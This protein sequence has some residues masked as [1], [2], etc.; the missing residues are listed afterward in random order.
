V[1]T[2]FDYTTWIQ[3]SMLFASIALLKGSISLYAHNTKQPLK[4]QYNDATRYG[5]QVRPL[6]WSGSGSDEGQGVGKC[7]GRVHG[8][9]GAPSL[10]LAFSSEC[11]QA[12]HQGRLLG[13]SASQDKRALGGILEG[14]R[15]RSP[16]GYARTQP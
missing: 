11:A 3:V 8:A 1:D 7:S 15:E 10:L 5:G 13:C 4:V 6:T 2:L 12:P 9:R 16:K 14:I